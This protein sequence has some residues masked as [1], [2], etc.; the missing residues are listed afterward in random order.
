MNIGLRLHDTLPGTLRERLHY[1]S[2]QGFTCVQ[3]AMSKSVP[4]FRM[5]DAPRLLTRELAAEVREELARAKM[6]CAVLGCYLGMTVWDEET[7]EKT[8]EIYLSHLRFA[9]WIG[10]RC[11]GTETP[12]PDAGDWAPCQTEEMYQLFLNRVTPILR[13]AEENGALLAIEPVC[14]HIVHTPALAERMLNDLNSD[15]LRIILD[16]VNLIDSAHADTAESVIQDGIRR[17]GSSTAVLHMKDFVPAP[18]KPRPDS[19]PCGRG[20][21]KYDSLLALARERDLPM[22]LEDTKPDNAEATRKYLEAYS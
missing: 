6:E 12:S 15:H 3:L 20:R 5:E 21:M 22:T 18:G 1:A 10:A 2:E 14:A 11:V 4:G 7:A 16:A 19:V 17:L 8:R 9:S 13:A